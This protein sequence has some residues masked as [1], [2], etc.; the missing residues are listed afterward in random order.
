VHREG[1]P[2]VL[3]VA[4]DR[5][6]GVHSARPR[7]LHEERGRRHRGPARPHAPPGGAELPDP[8]GG[9]LHDPQGEPPGPR[10]GERGSAPLR[11]AP[12]R[13]LGDRRRLPVIP[14]DAGY[15]RELD[16]R[17]E[18]ARFRAEFVGDDPDVIYLDGNSLG[19]LSRRAAARLREV[20]ETEW[21]RRLI[22]GWGEASMAA[23]RRG[24]G[25]PARPVR[26]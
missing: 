12:H 11:A 14:T 22:R 10:A 8:P 13:A 26:A 6:G 15:A 9:A 20:V 18:L 2:A 24:G 19:R 23:P 5:G 4:E 1:P 16:G 3:R 17:D 7:G 25:Q 21:G